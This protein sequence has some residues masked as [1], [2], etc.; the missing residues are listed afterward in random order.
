[1]KKILFA[2]ILLFILSGC[3]ATKVD[4]SNKNSA[5]D[6]NTYDTSN[7]VDI[8]QLKIKTDFITEKKEENAEYSLSIIGNYDLNSD[9]SSDKINLLLNSRV[10][11]KMSNLQVNDIK[12]N[13]QLDNPCEAF[14]IDLDKNDKYKEIAILDDGPSG[15]PCIIFFRFTGKEI[16]CMGS[17]REDVR[18]DSMGKAISTWNISNLGIDIVFCIYEVE[19]NKIITKANDY[20]SYL[21]KEYP[22]KTDI[23][24]YF[25]EM[26]T[27][28]A[29]F[30]PSYTENDKTSKFSKNKK[31]I[32]KD[33]KIM[34]YH[35]YWYYVEFEDNKK[36]VLYFWNGD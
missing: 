21:N 4:N 23:D 24:A 14:I 1:M 2:T 20:K 31:F 5:I 27:V 8:A 22:L 35:P 10:K 19:N 11:N 18:I 17:I 3:S 29:D 15:D 28:P 33:I 32:L 34:F 7:F 16:I 36:G 13:Y 9:N 6:S 30:V 25:K 26:E 12:F